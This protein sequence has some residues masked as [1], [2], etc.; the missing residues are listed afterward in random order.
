[1][2]KRVFV[3][4]PTGTVGIALVEYLLQCGCEVVA[5]CKK[6]SLRIKTLP[7][8]PDL[9]IVECDLDS[10]KEFPADKYGK[11]NYFFHLAWAGT[12]GN[13]RNNLKLQLNNV[14]Y[15][16][17]CVHL[18]NRLGCSKFIGIGS[19]A[20]YG[21]VKEKLTA[22]TPTNPITGYGICKLCA[23]Q[24]C[25]LEAQ[26][27]GLQYNWIRLLSVY[28]PY[29]GAHTLIMS[30]FD[31]MIR[32]ED[33]K[34]TAGIQIWDY[35]YSKDAAKALWMIAERGSNG[36]VYVLGSG[37]GAPLKH[38][39]E[40]MKKIVI[41]NSRLLWGEIAYTDQ[42]VMYLCADTAELENEIGFYP[43]T[44]FDEGIKETYFW[45]KENYL[46]EKNQHCNT[47]L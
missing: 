43:E 30:C 29:D 15:A 21:L 32:G 6:G 24:I 47:L 22:K 14:Q 28:G 1:M 16:L 17:D 36:K 7:V 46:Y 5:I 18:A 9:T 20:E 13:E 2:K 31:K 27:M 3:T 11:G 34:L 35:L 42:S 45:Y 33:I 19:Q 25:S 44:V 23:S 26:R 40:T 38:Y 10:M 41:S 37:T 12:S 8:N 4:G 39:I